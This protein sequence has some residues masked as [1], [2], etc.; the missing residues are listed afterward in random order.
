MPSAQPL[1]ERVFDLLADLLVR[2]VGQERERALG[3]SH[4]GVLLQDAVAVA[5]KSTVSVEVYSKVTSFHVSSAARSGWQWRAAAVRI[6][7]PSF[8]MSRPS[9]RASTIASSATRF[10]DGAGLDA[11]RMP[12]GAAAELQHHVFAEIVQQLVHLA[13][14]DS[15]GS[16]RHHLAQAGPVLLEEQAV[17]QIL[18][19]ARLAQRVVDARDHRRVAFE[20][21][22]HRARVDVIDARQGAS[23]SR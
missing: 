15:A 14:V 6:S 22:D 19:V 23:T 3:D 13:G 4:V 10:A 9:L 17:R 21:A 11:H 20:L 16:H 5:T 12:D 1:L 18:G 7:G 8:Q 2:Q